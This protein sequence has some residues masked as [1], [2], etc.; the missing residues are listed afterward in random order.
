MSAAREAPRLVERLSSMPPSPLHALLLALLLPLGARAA[1]PVVHDG[2]DRAEVLTRVADRTGLPPDQLEAVPLDRLLGEPVQALGGGVMR[3]CTG[4]P[5]A[6]ATPESE[7]VRAEAAWAQ[8]DEVGALDHLDLAVAALGCLSELV[9]PTVAARTFL[10]RGALE[11][12]RGE[13]EAALGELR[14]AL[15]F[16]P[17]LSWDSRFPVEGEVL[18][19][20]ATAA[21]EAYT[22]SVLPPGTSSGPWVDGRIV[23]GDG[24][25]LSVAPGLHLAQHPT[26]AGIRSAWL[27][28][29]GDATI[30]LPGMYRRP[31]LALIA[32]PA[33]RAPVERLLA[34]TLPGAPAAYVSWGGGMWLVS[35]QGEAPLTEELVAVPPPPAPTT[36]KR[37][38]DRR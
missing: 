25:G 14:A 7:L 1:V 38:K 36:G 4:A 16:Q 8:G 21:T 37:K 24:A 33:T 5:T 6:R 13:E 20:Q 19:A 3:R 26:P 2:G 28:V 12:R 17:D 22:V 29:E 34:A 32:D 31:V 18:L 27:V 23:P 30:V 35:L 10:L 9:D 11:A 15:S